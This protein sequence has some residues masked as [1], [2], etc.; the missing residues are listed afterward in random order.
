MATG[1][2]GNPSQR[3]Q[4]ATLPTPYGGKV[5]QLMVDVDPLA[6]QTRGLSARDVNNALLNQVMTTPLGD[7]AS[8]IMIIASM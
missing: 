4:G 6:M 7:S 2:S 5:R 8:E 3:F 1:G